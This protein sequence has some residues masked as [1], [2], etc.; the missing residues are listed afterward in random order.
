M[1]KTRRSSTVH[2]SK[3]PPDEDG[4]FQLGAELVPLFP[5]VS[6]PI[7]L[8]SRRLHPLRHVLL[9]VKL[10]AEL[11]DLLCLLL[12]QVVASSLLPCCLPP[13]PM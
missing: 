10:G 7:R 11:I 12:V 6:L 5:E 1:K 3:G 8:P 13:R 4:H 2:S 9:G